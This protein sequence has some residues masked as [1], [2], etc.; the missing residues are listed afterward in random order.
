MSH[1]N[2][3]MLVNLHHRYY[4]GDTNGDDSNRLLAVNVT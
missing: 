2:G 1:T 4:P 3:Q